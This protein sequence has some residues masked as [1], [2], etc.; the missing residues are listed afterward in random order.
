MANAII[1][2]AKRA[3]DEKFARLMTAWINERDVLERLMLI[4]RRTFWGTEDF[5]PETPD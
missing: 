2:K 4:R 5:E 1:I 3:R